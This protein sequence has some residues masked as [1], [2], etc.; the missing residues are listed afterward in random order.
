MYHYLTHWQKPLEGVVKFYL[1]V[2]ISCKHYKV[3]DICS[4]WIA[5]TFLKGKAMCQWSHFTLTIN[6]FL[7]SPFN[8]TRREQA[9]SNLSIHHHSHISYVA[10]TDLELRS[11]SSVWGGSI[12][13]QPLIYFLISLLSFQL[14]LQW[15]VRQTKYSVF[16]I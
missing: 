12:F 1:L 9:L 14:G 7:K 11:Q 6:D 13:L 4:G 2:L 5:K 3:V 10:K 8:M 16:A 15:W